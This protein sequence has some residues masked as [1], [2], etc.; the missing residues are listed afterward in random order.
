MAKKE[1][2]VVLLYFV[3]KDLPGLRLIQ[4][5]V[6]EERDQRTRWIG[7]YRYSNLNYETLPIAAM[8]AMQ[9]GQALECLIKEVVIAYLAL[10]PVNVLKADV[11]DGFYHIGL[12]PSDAPNM[13]LIFTLEVEDDN[14]AAI[15]IT[16]PMGE[17]NSLPIFCTATDNVVDLENAALRCNTISLPNDLY[18]M[19]KS[20][21]RVEPPTPQT[22]L[23]GMTRDPYLRRSNAKPAAYVDFFINDFLRIVQGPTHRRRRVRKN[24]FHTLYTVFHT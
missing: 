19:T 1:R 4:P 15:P 8:S 18:D 14:L 2:W 12:H 17:K 24:L 6:K 11:S 7:N 16:L 9:Y 21:L 3:D 13:G 23:T 10:G 5:G 22:V 20:I